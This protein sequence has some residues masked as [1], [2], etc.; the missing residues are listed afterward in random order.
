MRLKKKKKKKKKK[1][2]EALHFWQKA[3]Q[4]LCPGYDTNLY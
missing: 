3:F 1:K 4:T 2:N